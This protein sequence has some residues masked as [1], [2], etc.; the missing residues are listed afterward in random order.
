MTVERINLSKVSS[1][2][3]LY[4]RLEMIADDIGLDLSSANKVLN[5]G[6]TG[7]PIAGEILAIFLVIAE[8]FLMWS[9]SFLGRLAKAN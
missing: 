7:K 5:L 2:I 6:L 3:V 1:G 4:E 9:R 8:L